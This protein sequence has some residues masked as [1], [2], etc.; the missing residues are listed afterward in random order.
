[1][2]WTILFFYFSIVT[3]VTLYLHS[4]AEWAW[5]VVLITFLLL[6]P[7]VIFVG[8]ITWHAVPWAAVLSYLSALSLLA[9]VAAQAS[10]SGKARTAFLLAWSVFMLA[11][12]IGLCVHPMRSPGWG[13]F[14]GFWGV[15]GVLWLIV[16]QILALSDVLT[17]S[18]YTGASAWPLALVGLWFVVASV[19]GFGAAPIP[20][21]LDIVGVLTGL[22]LI[23]ISVTTW[24]DLPQL[25]QVAGVFSAAAYTVWVAGLGWILWEMRRPARRM[26]EPAPMVARSSASL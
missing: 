15:V 4:L 6:L 11:V 23:A 12:A 21:W 8:V 3:V 7:F 10:G 25:R 2:R 17:G 26:P 9:A 22:G 24:A 19:N 18:A 14:I 20:P 13:L 16:I 5:W 1:M